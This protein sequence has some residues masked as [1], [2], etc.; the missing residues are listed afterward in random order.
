MGALANPGMRI[1]DVYRL[2][3]H[4]VLRRARQ[5]L[6]NDAEAEE[7]MQDLFASLLRK[8]DQF[9]GE[10]RIT[11]FL[12]AA[13]T[14]RCLNRLRD[15]KNRARLVELFVKPATETSADP[16][17]ER[18]TLLRELLSRL[19]EELSEVAVYYYFDGMTH[20]EISDVLGC[21][22][23]QVGKLLEKFRASAA[24]HRRT[25]DERIG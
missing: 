17:A 14:H 7:V 6:H 10:S 3:G 12:Y 1:E 13:T 4:V 11:T 24:Q 9:R 19:P 22:R 15:R 25:E 21:S 16:K 18:K 20:D 23:R 2:H 8:P 5:I